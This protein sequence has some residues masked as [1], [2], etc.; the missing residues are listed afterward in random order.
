MAWRQPSDKP[1]SEPRMESL[2]MHICITRPQWVKFSRVLFRY[3]LLRVNSIVAAVELVIP[4]MMALVRRDMNCSQIV[5]AN[6]MIRYWLFAGCRKATPQ[7]SPVSLHCR[8]CCQ[9]ARWHHDMETHCALL[10]LYE[11]NPLVTGW[12]LSQMAAN[13][14]LQ[15]PW[16]WCDVT[17]MW[18]LINSLGRCINFCMN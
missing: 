9:Y 5:P 13:V 4:G 8:A 2:L 3:D 15:T 18:Y 11:V 7:Q 12:F 14:N 16:R 17:I 10:F 1:L 6:A